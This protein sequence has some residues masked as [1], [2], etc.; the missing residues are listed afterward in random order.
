MLKEELLSY[1][2][3]QTEQ[4]D[5]DHVDKSCT[6]DEMSGIFQVKRNTVSHYLNKEVGDSLFKVNTRPVLFFHAKV[7]EERFFKA[8]KPV[9]AS[10]DELFMKNTGGEENPGESDDPLESMIGAGGVL[11]KPSSRSR[12]LYFI[13]IP[14]C[15]CSSTGTR[16]P[17]RATWPGRFMSFLSATECFRRERRSSRL[18]VPSMPTMWS[19][20]P[21]IC[22]DM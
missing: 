9:Y 15:R 11:K 5:F 19:C 16:E 3:K 12:L 1:I 14:A 10:L 13:Q 20:C 8:E 4:I 2:K 21:A 7:F 6:A 18:T 22:S 17:G